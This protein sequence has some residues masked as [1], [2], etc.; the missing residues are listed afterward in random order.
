ME[1]AISIPAELGIFTPTRTVTISI[2]DNFNISVASSAAVNDEY[3]SA[4]FM[5]T[6]PGAYTMFVYARRNA[7]SGRAD[8]EVRPGK[9]FTD[10][11]FNETFTFG[12]IDLYSGSST[13]IL[14]SFKDIIVLSP[15]SL[16]LWY[17]IT[18]KQLLS[19]GF[20]IGLANI[21]LVKQ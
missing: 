9:R 8:F 13:T 6:E 15:G 4:H 1:S 19:T 3:L 5:V 14:L 10:G 7:S 11:L 18:G 17:K 21:V 2:A 12:N 20:G 16:Q